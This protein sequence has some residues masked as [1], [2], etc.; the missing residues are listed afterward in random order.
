MPL[1]QGTETRKRQ[2]DICVLKILIKK[3]PLKQGTET[4]EHEQ[5]L[6]LDYY[7]YKKD[8]PKAG[9]GNRLYR[10]LIA[11][12]LLYKKDAPKAGDGNMVSSVV[13]SRIR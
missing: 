7:E 6:L 3:M 4:I 11:L 10:R 12:Y 1:K 5:S 2:K 9:D 8:A 13:R